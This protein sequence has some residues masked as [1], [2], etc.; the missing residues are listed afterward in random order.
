MGGFLTDHPVVGTALL[1]GVLGGLIAVV[2]RFGPPEA[3]PPPV[4]PPVSLEMWPLTGVAVDQVPARPALVVKVSNSP[5][6]RPQTG[7]DVADVVLE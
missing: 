5:E 1:V 7:L 3:A 2:L 4:E 6:A